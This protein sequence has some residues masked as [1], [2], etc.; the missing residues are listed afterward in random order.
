MYVPMFLFIFGIE[1]L[2]TTSPDSLL[3]LIGMPV[4]FLGW[5]IGMV[6][7]VVSMLTAVVASSHMVANDEFG[8][9]FRLRE[10]WPIFKKNAAGYL[11]AF[12]ILM[13]IHMLVMMVSQVLVY[14]IILCCLYPVL[15]LV[16][17]VYLML[18]GSTFFAQAY[19]EGVDK[20]AK[21]AAQKPEAVE[22]EEDEAPQ[23]SEGDES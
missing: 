7:L 10:M 18:I 5:G 17:Q 9:A 19:V 11:I 23:E 22:A 16:Y 13:G 1:F 20:L 6:F 21:A 14:T 3:P 8:A 2:E 4:F 15:L 12:V